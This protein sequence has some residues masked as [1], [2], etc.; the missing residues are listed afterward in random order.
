M[1]QDQKLL[2]SDSSGFKERENSKSPF[3]GHES[4]NNLE[5]VQHNNSKAEKERASKWSKRDGMQNCKHEG[6]K[7]ISLTWSQGDEIW[8][9]DSYENGGK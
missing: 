4:K 7:E 1:E 5:T 2:V 8:C 9:N 3:T 6:T